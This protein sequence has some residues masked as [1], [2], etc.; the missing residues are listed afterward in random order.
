MKRQNKSE[1]RKRLGLGAGMPGGSGTKGSS[2][3]VTEEGGAAAGPMLRASKSLPALA[4][5]V[6]VAVSGCSG[7]SSCGCGCSSRLCISVGC[8][9]TL[10]ERRELTL[11]LPLP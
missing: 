6:P 2:E 5:Y 11:Q 3:A 9:S 1:D 8:I 10:Q 4:L 7:C